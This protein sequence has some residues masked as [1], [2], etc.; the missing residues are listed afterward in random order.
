MSGQSPWRL[1][2]RRLRRNKLAIFFT[3]VF[4]ALVALALCAPLYA[5]HVAH[6]TPD[7]NNITGKVTVDGEQRD[8]VSVDGIPIKPTWQGEYALGADTNGRDVAVRLFYAARNSMFIALT[9]TVI[10]TFIGIF[11][12]LVAGFYRGSTDWI[13]SRAMDVMWAIPVLLLG[14]A[15]GVSLA[16]GGVSIGPVTVSGDSLWIPTLIIGVVSVVYLARPL[17]GEVLR[18][19]EQEFVEAARAQGAS[20][21]RI[22]FGE[23]LPNI[24]TTVLVFFP[25]LVANAVLL[26][27][28]LSFLGAGVR[29][30]DPSWG[31]MIG[32]GQN[33]LITQPALT[34]APGLMLVLTV[35][36]LNVVGEA[37]RE[38]IDPRARV[39]LEQ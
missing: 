2:W 13:I 30:P 33:V 21:P 8:V 36:A 29:D 9:A 35:L 23:I 20:G 25:L 15:L 17:R 6:T 14:V 37:V 34:I 38:A 10:T 11:L 22:M 5:E 7:R 18:L 3:I 39:V 31:T 27:A 19:R 12:G 16:L 28:A 32:E 1:A 24:I 4:L 26:E